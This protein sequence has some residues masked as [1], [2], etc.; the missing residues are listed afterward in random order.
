M[1]DRR[2]NANTVN[3]P[4]FAH[5][6]GQSASDGMGWNL[7]TDNRRTEEGKNGGGNEMNVGRDKWR[8]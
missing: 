8:D 6:S 7:E 2:T 4:L 3:T 1:D 5:L